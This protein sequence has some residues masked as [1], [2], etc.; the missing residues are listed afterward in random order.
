MEDQ[1]VMGMEFKCIGDLAIQTSFNLPDIL[2]RGNS[3][4]VTHPENVRIHGDDGLTEG[5]VQDYIRGLATYTG[6]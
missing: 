1:P 2:A 4:P 6:Q 5:D 3:G